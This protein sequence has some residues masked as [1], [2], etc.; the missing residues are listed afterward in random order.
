LAG[1]IRQRVAALEP[2]ERRAAM[3]V[4]VAGDRCDVELLVA[5]FG[6]DPI[7]WLQTLS[8]LETRH[9]LLTSSGRAFRFARPAV[10]E[11]VYALIDADERARAHGMLAAALEARLPPKPSD[12]DRL[13]VAEHARRSNDTALAL[14]HLPQV[15]ESLRRRGFF[16]R[17]LA[18]ARAAIDLLNQLPRRERPLLETRFDALATSAECYSRL[19]RRVEERR[20][21]EKC[22]RIARFLDDP[23]RLARTLHSLGRLAHATGRYLVAASYLDRAIETARAAGDA[24]TEAEAL[25]ARAVAASYAGDVD[26]AGPLVDRALELATD[27]DLRARALLQ[28]G[29]RWINLDRPD[30]A[31][32]RIEA[33]HA[34]FR[35]LKM[36]AAQASAHFHRARA[37]AEIGDPAGALRDLDRALVLARES[38]ERRTEA[39]ALSLRGSL[40]AAAHEW[41]GAES[42]LRAALA[43]AGEIGDRFT[44]CHTALHLANAHLSR[45]NPRR[46][47]KEA[48]RLA[49]LGLAI[50]EELD[51]PRLRALAHAVRARGHLRSGRVDDALAESERAVAVLGEGP[52]DRRREVSV[53]YTRGLVLREAGREDE[54]KDWLGRAA[55]I[56]RERAERIEDERVRKSFLEQEAFHR[57]VLAA[58]A[59]RPSEKPSAERTPSTA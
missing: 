49:R 25:L 47:P 59:G 4:A 52:R 41:E 38:G 33:A 6:G 10:R 28:Q 27:S 42:D 40:R 9:A 21:L 20:T 22:A 17:A 3:F 51:L 57:K 44:E 7:S 1:A 32:E 11:V 48:M 58:A 18:L 55:A 50:A 30:L 13:L 34:V 45:G 14:R 29:L 16:E 24:R 37:R 36:P 15:A 12:R 35:E 56:L 2:E 5:A 53:L 46:N 39:S 26:A 31:I 43:L 8:R 19:G 54:A 23:S